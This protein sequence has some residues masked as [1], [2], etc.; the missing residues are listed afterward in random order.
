MKQVI[1]CNK[2]MVVSPIIV[3]DLGLLFSYHCL[4]CKDGFSSD[5]YDKEDF[6]ERFIED[7]K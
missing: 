7:Q 4:E 5:P 2:I 3:D 1:C 6:W